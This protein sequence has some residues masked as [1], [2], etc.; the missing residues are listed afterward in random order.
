M[1]EA[2]NHGAQL[3]RP[4]CMTV[5]GLLPPYELEDVKAAYRTK[6]LTAHPDHGGDPAD[7]M[8]LKDAYDQAVEYATFR[9]SRRAWIAAQVEQHLNQEEVIAE[10]LR[11]GGRVEVERI[12]WME[13][14]WGD[15]FPLLAERLRHIYVRDMED[16]DRFLAFLADHRP[17]YLL[18]LDVAGSRFSA[19]GLRRLAGYE[20]MRWLN[21]SRIPVGRAVLESVLEGLPSLESLN[22][23]R[24]R[25]GWWGRWLLRRTYPQ[26]EV[27]V[28][29]SPDIQPGNESLDS[30]DSTRRT[31]T[32]RHTAARQKPRAASV[33][34][35]MSR[36][37]SKPDSASGD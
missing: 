7:F 36:L 29:V 10:V 11:R 14:S 5:L 15:G 4:A 34:P 18:G 23:R 32:A 31:K 28:E 3:D 21:V 37:E 8:R 1:L 6:V 27:V 19:D 9:G 20:V 30:L 25:L 24:T 26:I 2:A 13:N 12:A 33:P 16:G 35:Q 17:P 22:V